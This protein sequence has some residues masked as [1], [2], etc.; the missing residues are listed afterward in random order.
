MHC[1]PQAAAA[2]PAIIASLRARGHN[3]VTLPAL[4]RAAGYR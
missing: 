2:L 3:A 1:T 4:S